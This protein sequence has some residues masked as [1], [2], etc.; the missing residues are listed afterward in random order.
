MKPHS[1]AITVPLPAFLIAVA[2]VAALLVSAC[3]QTPTE[4]AGGRTQTPSARPP[5]GLATSPSP[6]QKFTPSPAVRSA[7]W[8]PG[9]PVPEHLAGSWQGKYALQLGAYTFQFVGIDGNV[10]VNGSEI[11][12]MSND[13]KAGAIGTP[14]AVP[15]FGFDRYSYT[16][17][18]NNLVLLRVGPY[19]CGWHIQGTYL[20]IAT[21]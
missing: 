13:C 19:V 8:P 9:G 4:A 2:T 16:L 17:T 5:E 20:R 11:D 21:P 12:F 3:S 10:V 1:V 15:V 14:S 6:P 7:N 18:G